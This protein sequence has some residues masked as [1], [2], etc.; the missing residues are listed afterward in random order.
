MILFYLLLSESLEKSA[1][2]VKKLKLVAISALVLLVGLGIVEL[3]VNLK[4]PSIYKLD[5]ILGW[6]IKPNFQH[7]YVQKNIDRT[8]YSVDFSTNDL[9]LRVYGDPETALKKM[10]VVG[11]SYT[12]EPYASNQQMWWAVGA[13]KLADLN[14]SPGSIYAVAG[15][16]G[17]WGT[18]QELVLVKNIIQKIRPDIFVL[19]FC[20]NDFANNSQNLE[21]STITRSQKFRRPYMTPSGD[22]AFSTEWIAPL[23]RLPGI[24]QSRVLNFMDVAVQV[25]QSYYYKNKFGLGWGAPIDS[26]LKGELDAESLLITKRLLAEMRRSVGD[27]PAFMVNCNN[28]NKGLNARWREM[29]IETGFVPLGA[30]S[31]SI[32]RI[33]TYGGDMISYIDGAHLN[34]RGNEVYGNAFG[35]E[36]ARHL[37]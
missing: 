36:L 28:E 2:K 35:E 16:G 14:H 6:T 13:K 1:Y 18:Y 37:K 7:A 11:D 4:N 30:P 33:R 29:A 25:G 34:V 32:E 22:I 8:S 31:G 17:G 3:W 12:M 27:V 23:W 20:D 19:Q 15:G 24:G 10:L 9:G 26:Q 5:S 21:A